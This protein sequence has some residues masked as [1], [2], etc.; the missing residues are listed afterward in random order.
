MKPIEV[1]SHI[2]LSISLIASIVMGVYG[3]SEHG[4]APFWVL[5]VLGGSFVLGTQLMLIITGE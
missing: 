3:L 2:V 5:L 4:I 1:I